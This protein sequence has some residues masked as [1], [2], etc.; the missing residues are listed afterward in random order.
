MSDSIVYIQTFI[1]QVLIEWVVE[2]KM[3]ESGEVELSEITMY[4]GGIIDT[5][6]LLYLVGNANQATSLFYAVEVGVRCMIGCIQTEF[7]YTGTNIKNVG[8]RYL[9]EKFGCL[10]GDFDRC[11][12]EVG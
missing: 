6:F 8:T 11:P 9:A 5:D 1:Y 10:P 7:S 2:I 12:V 4:E 3:I